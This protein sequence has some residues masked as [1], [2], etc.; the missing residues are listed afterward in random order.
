[1]GH[2]WGLVEDEVAIQDGKLPSA[3]VSRDERRERVEA[4]MAKM[5]RFAAKLN[6]SNADLARELGVARINLYR[7]RRGVAVPGMGN[8]CKLLRLCLK[9]E[10]RAFERV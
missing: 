10:K 7:W 5:L 4:L 2:N 9:L 8:Y 3:L 1:M 6:V